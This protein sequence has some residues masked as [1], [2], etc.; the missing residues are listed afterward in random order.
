MQARY[1]NWAGA[2]TS[3]VRL[4][5]VW[6]MDRLRVVPSADKQSVDIEVVWRAWFNPGRAGSQPH[7]AVFAGGLPAASQAPL[8]KHGAS[9]FDMPFPMTPPPESET[10]TV[11]MAP[12]GEVK[13]RRRALVVRSEGHIRNDVVVF[14]GRP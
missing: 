11:V 3:L 12:T 14:V 2:W 13:G 5:P 8:S 10:P 1:E 7:N 4:G 9:V 6:S